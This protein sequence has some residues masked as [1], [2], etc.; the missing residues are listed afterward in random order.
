MS[1]CKIKCEKMQK[2][3]SRVLTISSKSNAMLQ[4]YGT[5]ILQ[6]AIRLWMASVFL[7]S[8][9]VKFSNIDSAVSLFEYEYKVP[10]ISPVFATY[11][12]MTFEIGCSILLIFGFATRLAALPLIIMTLVIQLFVFQNPEHLYWLFLFFT[13]VVYGAGQISVDYLINKKYSKKPGWLS[14]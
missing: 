2:L 14:F 10:L 9:L 6:F 7:K 13:L 12:S 5:P 4:K 3:C 11:L 1:I 8:G